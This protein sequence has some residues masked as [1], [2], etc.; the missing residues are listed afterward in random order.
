MSKEFPVVLCRWKE[1]FEGK[2]TDSTRGSRMEKLDVFHSYVRPTWRPVL[3]DFCTRLTGITQ[4][5][6][7]IWLTSG[8]D[9]VERKC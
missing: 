8:N 9:R 1:G 2:P 4:V 3:S 6:S 5:S 7:L